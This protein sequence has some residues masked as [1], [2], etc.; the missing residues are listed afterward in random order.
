MN[1]F[2]HRA[3][4]RGRDGAVRNVLAL[5]REVRVYLRDSHVIVGSTVPPKSGPS[6]VF[7]IR[8]WGLRS[9]M[10]LRFADVLRAAPVRRMVWAEQRTI[11]AAQLAGVFVPQPPGHA[12]RAEA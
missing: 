2:E 10:T 7:H 3:D 4:W 5:A 9:T 8:P 6:E 11:A 12:R 1:S